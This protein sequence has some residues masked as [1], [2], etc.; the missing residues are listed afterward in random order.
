MK[1]LLQAQPDQRPTATEALQHAWLAA[2]NTIASDTNA[3]APSKTY[4]VHQQDSNPFAKS[5]STV[6]L[7]MYPTTTA[8][9]KA[10][11]MKLCEQVPKRHQNFNSFLDSAPST[12]LSRTYD[13]INLTILSIIETS[14]VKQL[15]ITGT[16]QR[17]PTTAS[18]I[19]Q[20]L[21]S[22]GSHAT[23]LSPVE[24]TSTSSAEGPKAS[25]G[26]REKTPL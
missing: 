22:Q 5:A 9:V 17:T 20:K 14:T 24:A 3:V 10:T 7:K 18:R 23:R 16:A 21:P 4:P 2:T 11:T 12:G 6:D 8:L 26:Q 19:S 25:R 15:A 1:V 13:Q